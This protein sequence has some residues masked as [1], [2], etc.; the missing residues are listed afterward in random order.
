MRSGDIVTWVSQS[1]GCEKTKT[2]TVIAEIKA[3]QD[4]MWFVPKSA[5]KSH[6]KFTD[7]SSKDRVLIAVPGGKDGKIIH[8]YCPLKSVL[9]TQGY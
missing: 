8:Y 2:G 5:K 7:I 1:Q 9:E 4:A 3:G 6:I